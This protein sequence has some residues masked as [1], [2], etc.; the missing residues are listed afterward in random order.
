VSM[1]YLSIKK[2]DTYQ[3]YK[4]RNPPWIKLYRCLLN[5]YEMRLLPIHSRMAYICLLIIASETDNR[6]PIDYKYLSD[7]CGFDVNEMTVTRLIDSGFLIALR[8]RRAIARHALFSSL[9]SSSE[10]DGLS[11]L[12]SLPSSLKIVPDLKSKKYAGK[13]SAVWETYRASFLGRW[14]VE[15]IRDKQTNSM[16]CKLVEKLGDDI[17]SHV[18][19]FYLTH[20][21]PFYVENRH[22]VNVLLRDCHGLHTQWATG[23]KATTGELKNAEFKDNVVEQVKRIEALRQGERT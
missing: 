17:A 15:P 6:I 21:K 4:T 14:K 19:A 22:P 18:A 7:R 1:Q 23:T 8:A 16:L 5:D 10:E 11:S 12:D 9:L 13:S 3:H 2:Y 20:N